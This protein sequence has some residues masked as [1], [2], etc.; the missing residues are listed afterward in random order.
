MATK[1]PCWSC[2]LISSTT[3]IG[4]A[5]LVGFLHKTQKSVL[6]KGIVL[7]TAGAIGS[8]GVY[9]FSKIRWSDVKFK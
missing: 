3:L 8:F 4:I 6:N 2:Q 9:N 1:T 7:A 5:T